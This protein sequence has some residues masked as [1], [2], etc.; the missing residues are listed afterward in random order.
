MQCE[1]YDPTRRVARGRHRLVLGRF[2]QE[3][4]SHVLDPRLHRQGLDSSSTTS[5]VPV[6]RIGINY[7]LKSEV[8]GSLIDWTTPQHV[9][10]TTGKKTALPHVRQVRTRAAA[11]PG[12]GRA[13]AALHE[14][15]DL[16][17][18]DDQDRHTGDAP[19]RQKLFPRAVRRD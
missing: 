19:A 10:P 3:G 17:S 16:Q 13:R 8:D 18:E 6:V 4:G 12:P 11:A 1:S 14:E 2:Q 7:L 5:P 15:G 9:L